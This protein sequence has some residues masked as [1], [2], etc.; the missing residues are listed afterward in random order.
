MALSNS[1]SVS[2]SRVGRFRYRPKATDA[3]HAFD[4]RPVFIKH[5]ATA[6][7]A[8]LSGGILNVVALPRRSIVIQH[9][10]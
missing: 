3:T 7:L 5:L 4:R 6:R 8:G 1:R 2:V 9:Y 10:R